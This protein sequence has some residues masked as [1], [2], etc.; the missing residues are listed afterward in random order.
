MVK[1]FKSV[2]CSLEDIEVY[3]ALL[4]E[5]GTIRVSIVKFCRYGQIVG[6]QAFCGD[7]YLGKTLFLKCVSVYYDKWGFP[8]YRFSKYTGKTTNST[9]YND[10]KTKHLMGADY[11]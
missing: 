6:L 11:V 4:K 9:S 5:M 7:I 10:F 8:I 3:E 2:K 1:M